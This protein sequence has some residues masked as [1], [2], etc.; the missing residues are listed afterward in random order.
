MNFCPKCGKIMVDDP[1]IKTDLD[2]IKR[3]IEIKRKEYGFNP[4]TPLITNYVCGVRD[5]LNYFDSL[6]DDIKSGEIKPQG[7]NQ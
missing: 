6:V 2:I 3:H 4:T 7:I 5:V 1:D